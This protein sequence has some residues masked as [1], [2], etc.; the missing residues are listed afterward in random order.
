MHI[1]C[2]QDLLLNSINT[3]LKACSTKTTMPILECILLKA[4]NNKLTLVGNNL[5]LGIE[6]TI[7][8]DV[9][10]EGYIAL[11][12]KIFSEIIR[13]MPGEVVEISTDDNFMTSIISEKSK[14][15][16]AGQ[17][18]KDFP[19]LPDVEKA[20][21]CTVNQ[22]ALKEMIRQTIFSVAQD[23]TRPILTGEM[24]QIKNNNLNMV[25]VDGYRI[26]YRQ[27]QLSNEN[28]EIEVVIPGRTLSEINKI[29]TS[30]EKE[31]VTV[32]FGDKHV[33]FDLGDSK[34]VSRL[35]E[36]EFLKYEQVFSPDY[37]TKILV[38]RK[39][40]L[41]SIERAALISR[42]GKKN[43]IRVEINGE[44]M[45]ITS[46]AELGTAR[47]ELDVILEG[48]EITI[49]FNPKY[50]IDALKAIDDDN[51]C[52]HFISSLTPC[53]IQPE[54]GEHYKYLIL[55]IRVNA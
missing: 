45:I 35:L 20:N 22:L 53:I 36:G 50:L 17:S 3:V 2:R 18:G 38:D 47:E 7:D 21:I 5:E 13:R 51:V 6:S 25:S 8:A 49:A 12:S 31:D 4:S 16:I 55:P 54:E 15:Q 33:L 14:F 23:E 26:S 32:Y 46:N 24:L 11:E 9:I 30:E 29:L 42:E 48:K 39:N 37:E 41:M 52:I 19:A 10:N 44:K 28:G 34:V 40:F 43:P 27:L 1:Y